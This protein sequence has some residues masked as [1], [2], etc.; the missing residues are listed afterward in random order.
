MTHENHATSTMT[1]EDVWKEFSSRLRSYIRRQVRDDD[2]AED[3]LQ[4]VFLRM[5]AH[6]ATVRA[7]EKLAAWLYQVTRNAIVDHHRRG[8]PDRLAPLPPDAAERFA[9]PEADETEQRIQ[10]LLPCVRTMVEALPEPYREALLLTEYDGLTQKA[11]ADRLGLSFSGAKS[12]VQRAREKLRSLLLA[13]CHL[14]FDHAGRV[15]DYHPNCACCTGCGTSAGLDGA[16]CGS[17]IC[18]GSDET[19]ACRDKTAP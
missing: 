18:G 10:A 16:E 2:T 8:R 12:R 3:I 14:E 1:T 5:H 7:E 13:C 4:E 15:V 19:E 17:G 9:M 6:G 11:L